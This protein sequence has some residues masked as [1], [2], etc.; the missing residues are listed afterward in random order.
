MQRSTQRINKTDWFLLFGSLTQR[1]QNKT[2]LEVEI[3]TNLNTR[4]AILQS[5]D[6]FEVNISATK[7]DL[8]QGQSYSVQIFVKL[9]TVEGEHLKSTQP[10]A[11]PE[12]MR[13]RA[14]IPFD[15]KTGVT[16]LSHDI[17]SDREKINHNKYKSTRNPSVIIILQSIAGCSC[18]R[19]PRVKGIYT[20]KNTGSSHLK[21]IEG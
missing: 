7:I 13:I 11:F 16:S 9:R 14:A 12:K 15:A 2:S 5:G 6:L 21:A 18:I 4:L 20:Q 17:Y 1:Y 8:L 3:K 19:G 10:R